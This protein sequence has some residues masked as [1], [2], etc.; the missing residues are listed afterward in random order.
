MHPKY[1][2][3]FSAN[4]A[5]WPTIYIQ[6]VVP[7]DVC[8][9]FKHPWDTILVSTIQIHKAREFTKLEYLR[10]AMWDGSTS[11]HPTRSQSKSGVPRSKNLRC[12]TESLL[13]FPCSLNVCRLKLIAGRVKCWLP[14]IRIFGGLKLEFRFLN[15]GFSY[16]KT[17]AWAKSPC[18]SINIEIHMSEAGR[19]PPRCKLVCISPSNNERYSI[20]GRTLSPNG[21]ISYYTYEKPEI[22]VIVCYFLKINIKIDI[23]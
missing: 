5:W 21:G 2:W 3:R 8:R 17:C 14:Q 13:W 9:V 15:P 18:D 20:T 12:L 11:W 4:G 10:F 16:L 7:S 1:S 22:I 19:V 23:L 6:G